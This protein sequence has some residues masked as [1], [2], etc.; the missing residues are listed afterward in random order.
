VDIWDNSLQKSL[1]KQEFLI[2]G[3]RRL[4]IIFSVRS[5][6]SR[7]LLTREFFMGTLIGPCKKCGR[8]MTRP[9]PTGIC[10]D[11]RELLDKRQINDPDLPEP[12][13][14]D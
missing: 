10:G 9:H 7:Y 14:Y 4:N 3:K 12:I 1:M 8:L 2:G 11:C 13:R 6:H 5:N